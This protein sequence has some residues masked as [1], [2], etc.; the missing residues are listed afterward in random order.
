MIPHKIDAISLLNIVRKYAN[1]TDEE[2]L[3]REFANV[4]NPELETERMR[5]VST[6]LQIGL[7]DVLVGETIQVLDEVLP[8][9][10]AIQMVAKPLIRRGDI[11]EEY[12]Q[13]AISNIKSDKPFIMIAD[14]V[15]IAHAGVDDGAKRVCLSLLTMPERIDVAGYMEADMIIMIG[16]PDPTKHLEVLEQLNRILEDK[17]V[18]QLL[19][20]AK[21]PKDIINL[22]QKKEKEK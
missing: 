13:K 16:T 21:E 6:R 3:K 20:K 22:I 17:K 14:G 1:I 18:L 11:T 2:G 10:E 15:I 7:K 4:L 19:K 12:A 5:D 9:E 8:W